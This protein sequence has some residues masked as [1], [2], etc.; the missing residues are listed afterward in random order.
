MSSTLR[1]VMI[2]LSA[3]TMVVNV[4]PEDVKY[5]TK[6]PKE[7][8]LLTSAPPASQV[9]LDNVRKC[10]KCHSHTAERNIGAMPKIIKANALLQLRNYYMGRLRSSVNSKKEKQS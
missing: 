6:S 2:K 5:A 7:M 3:V 1:K 8:F 9:M 4:Y 10:C